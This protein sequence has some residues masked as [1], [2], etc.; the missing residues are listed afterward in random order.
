MRKKQTARQFLFS[1]TGSDCRSR[2]ESDLVSSCNLSKVPIPPTKVMFIGRNT[3]ILQTFTWRT[4]P[5]LD[6]DV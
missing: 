2:S 1:S 4:G 3:N 5:V 6:P